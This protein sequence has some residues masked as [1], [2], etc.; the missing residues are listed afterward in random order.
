MPVTHTAISV[1]YRDAT[2]RAVS[3]FPLIPLAARHACRH[4]FLRWQK[5]VLRALRLCQDLQSTQGVR[6]SDL[7]R[8]N[9]ALSILRLRSEL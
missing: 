4:A 5:L 1:R 7:L 2:V 9:E 8:V 3:V 6:C